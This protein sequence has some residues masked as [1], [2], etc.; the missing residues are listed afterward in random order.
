[1]QHNNQHSISPYAAHAKGLEKVIYIP[2]RISADTFHPTND[3]WLFCI[4]K[5]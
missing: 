1:M 2:A 5:L 4:A 3:I